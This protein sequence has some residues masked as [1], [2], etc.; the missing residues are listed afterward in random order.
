MHLHA[1]GDSAV[2][3]AL[4][5]VAALD[6]PG[7]LRHQVAHLQVV[8]PADVPRFGAAGGGGQRADAVGLPRGPDDRPGDAGARPGRSDTQYPFASMRRGGAVLG[9]GS[10][11]PVSTANPFA[12]IAVGVNR[13]VPGSVGGQAFLPEERLTVDEAWRRSPWAPRGPTTA[14]LIVARCGSGPSPT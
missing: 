12:Q 1:I 9:A 11:W 10:D 13:T 6:D 2:R 7:R 5:A 3:D 4:D 14:T 8:D